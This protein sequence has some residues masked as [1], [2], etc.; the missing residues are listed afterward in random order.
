MGVLSR[1][2]VASP[3]R[4]SYTVQ[5]IFSCAGMSGFEVFVDCVSGAAA[6]AEILLA[7]SR[8]AVI[9]LVVSIFS[10][11]VVVLAVSKGYPW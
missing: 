8:V 5:G 6:V 10:A 9:V 7:L 3:K 4:S 11:G 2:I 1:T